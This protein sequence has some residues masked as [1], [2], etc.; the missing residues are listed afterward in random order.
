MSM[1]AGFVAVAAGGAVGACAR[2]AITALFLG[3]NVRFPLATL[4]ANLGGAFLAG[5]L[6][7]WL[8]S[9]GLSASPVYLLLVTGFLGSFTTLSAFSLE[10]VKLLQ[11]GAMLAAF[12]NV[13]IT[14]VGALLAVAVG[15]M[16][17]KLV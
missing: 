1:G 9:R 12:G 4:L 11:N 2:Y 5:F 8:L 7:S 10:T 17:A 16:L 3:S 13:V 15:A 6:A 14:I